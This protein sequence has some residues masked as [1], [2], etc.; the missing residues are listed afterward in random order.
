MRVWVY[1]IKTLW[2]TRTERHTQTKT[3]LSRL[4][5]IASGSQSHSIYIAVLRMALACRSSA[6]LCEGLWWHR[7]APFT[8]TPDLNSSS[9]DTK[10]VSLKWHGF[11]ENW[12]HITGTYVSHNFHI[13]WLTIKCII[14]DSLYPKSKTIFGGLLLLRVVLLLWEKKKQNKNPIMQHNLIMGFYQISSLVYFP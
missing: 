5:S 2:H 9:Y 8:A 6:L 12:L 3:A 10:C 7:E 14:L 1:G 13:C 11:I 4:R